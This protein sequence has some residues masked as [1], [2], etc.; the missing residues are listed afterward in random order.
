MSSIEVFDMLPE[1]AMELDQ[2][3][4]FEK[5][6]REGSFSRAALA[7]GVGQ[8]AVSARI[9]ALEEDVGGA[10]FNRG[11][12]IALTALGESFLPYVRRALEVL[13]E[14]AES[15]RMAQVGKRGRVRLGALGSLAGGL[16]GPALAR[17][18]TT[19]PEVDCT[20]KSADHEFLVEL[21]LDGIIEL[22]LIAWP[23]AESAAAELTPLFVFQEPVVLAAHPRHPLAA[24]RSVTQD[25]VARLAR[26]LLQLRWWPSHHP[27]ITR[28]VQQSG[29]AME[30]PMET[31]RHLV[32]HGTGAGFFART[33]IA[34]DLAASALA[35]IAVRGLAPIVRGSA[36]VR[37]SRSTP[38]SPAAAALIQALRA[39]ADRLA[40]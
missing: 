32:L 1:E 19:H 33:Y 34:D 35:E 10:L 27:L 36:L 12:R 39:Q 16:V 4:A 24:R 5:V 23:C 7:L 3:A 13:R 37:R 9:Q 15:A 28:L 40:R 8:P 21:L 29:T 38:L 26:P 17:F 25:D 31:A 20:L 14:G 2:L 30:V 18:A 22:A 11:R 6:A